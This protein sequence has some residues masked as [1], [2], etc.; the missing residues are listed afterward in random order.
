[1]S[2]SFTD[3]LAEHVLAY[4]KE[5]GESAAQ[6]AKGCGVSAATI[7]S[8]ESGNANT[9]LSTVS[10]ILRYMNITFEELL[11]SLAAESPAAG[12][13]APSGSKRAIPSPQG[14][15]AEKKILF[16]E[17][18]ADIPSD[19]ALAELLPDAYNPSKASVTRLGLE[20]LKLRLDGL[21]APQTAEKLQLTR[22]QVDRWSLTTVRRLARSIPENIEVDIPALRKMLGIQ[23]FHFTGSYTKL[24]ELLRDMPSDEVLLQ[25]DRERGNLISGKRR[26]RVSSQDLYILQQRL[27]GRTLRSIG[28]ELGKSVEATRRQIWRSKVGLIRNLNVELDVPGLFD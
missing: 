7:R 11:P 8:I 25:F 18:L 5:H 22:R 16:S 23:P 26:R 12:E 3:S 9:K 14:E 19:E 20:I 24:S 17:L 6:F 28:G 1:M 27:A 4:R 21:D 10:K 13:K 15:M 2:Y